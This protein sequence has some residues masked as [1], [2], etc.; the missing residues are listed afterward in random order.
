M[1]LRVEHLKFTYPKAKEP[2]IRDISFE[3]PDGCI[4]VTFAFGDF[5]E[6]LGRLEGLR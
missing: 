4:T 2:V 6:R 5:D 1:S 3:A